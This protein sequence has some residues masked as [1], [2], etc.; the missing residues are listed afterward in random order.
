M[1]F[2]DPYSYKQNAP[3]II[4]GSSHVIPTT[5]SSIQR[6]D[7]GHGTVD[8]LCGFFLVRLDVPGRAGAAENVVHHPTKDRMPAVG[9]ALLQHQL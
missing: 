2:R 3:V 1:Q 5:D 7:R 6:H 9:D 4:D 8:F